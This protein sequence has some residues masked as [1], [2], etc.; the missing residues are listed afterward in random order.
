MIRAGYISQEV[1][2]FGDR[3]N[4]IIAFNLQA[5]FTG[6]FMND[7]PNLPKVFLTTGKAPDRRHNTGNSVLLPPDPLTGDPGKW[8]EANYKAPVMIL[9]RYLRL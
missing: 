7:I 2:T 8:I 3:E 6:L 4:G 9:A 1:D 5:G